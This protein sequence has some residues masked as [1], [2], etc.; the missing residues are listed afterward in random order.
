MPARP[1]SARIL[2]RMSSEPPSSPPPSGRSPRGNGGK[3]ETPSLPRWVP[4]VLGLVLLA[5][6]FLPGQLDSTDREE[7]PYEGPGGLLEQIEQLPDVGEEAEVEIPDDQVVVR[8]DW[9]NDTGRIRGE[10]E[11]GDEFQSNGPKEPS[12]ADRALFAEKGVRFEFDQGQD[13]KRHRA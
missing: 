4:W 3:P 11:S 12:D 2:S 6:L 7:L 8:M 9:N 1:L 5:V 10:Y 13:S